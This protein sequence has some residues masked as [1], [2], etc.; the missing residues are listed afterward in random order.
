M[1]TGAIRL[2]SRTDVATDTGSA[3]V[4][5]APA[6]HRVLS[7]LI[8]NATD[9]HVLS[10]FSM[11]FEKQVRMI[12]NL[13]HLHDETKDVGVVVQ[14]NTLG[15]VSVKLALAAGHDTV[16]KIVLFFSKELSVNVYFLDWKLHRVGMIL[17]ETTQH[18]AVSH[19]SQ[20]LEGL[21]A[22]TT[23]AKLLNGVEKLLVENRNMLH[24]S[25][26][27]AGTATILVHRPL[28]RRARALLTKVRCERSDVEKANQREKLSDSILERC[29]G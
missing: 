17:L 8:T 21:M 16:G 28:K 26:F 10:S 4:M 19:Q 22:R 9:K 15:D 11:L 25:V 6:A 14:K 7:W 29:A 5:F 18:D 23:V 3:K 20:L 13:S 27:T 24:T 2:I 1:T 12:C